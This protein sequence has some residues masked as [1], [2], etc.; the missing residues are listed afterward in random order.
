MPPLEKPP[1][2]RGRLTAGSSKAAVGTAGGKSLPV[3]AGRIAPVPADEVELEA[4][5]G[6]RIGGEVGAAAG[7]PDAA[8]LCRVVAVEPAA[9]VVA[10]DTDPDPRHIHQ[11]PSS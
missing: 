3:L 7:A 10:V 8:E 2:Q 5:V 11:A 1:L 6:G 4:A 9:A